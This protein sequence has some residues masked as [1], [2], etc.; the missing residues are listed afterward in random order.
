MGTVALKIANLRRHIRDAMIYIHVCITVSLFQCIDMK[1][2]CIN[3]LNFVIYISLLQMRD[4]W[5]LC[6]GHLTS[7]F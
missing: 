7:I 5:I 2:G 6:H 3:I 1:S 4:G